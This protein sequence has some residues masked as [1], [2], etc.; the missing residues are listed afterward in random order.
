MPNIGSLLKEEISRLCRKEIRSQVEPLR[1]AS[2]AYRREIAALKRQMSVVE[3]A[4][5]HLAKRSAK[6]EAVSTKGEPNRPL[7]F[8]A[9]G[10]VSLR[11]RLGLSASELAKLLGVSDQSVYNWEHKRATPRKEQLAALATI[12][13]LGKRE[14]RARL[15]AMVDTRV[16]KP[17]KKSK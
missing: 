17:R 10:L 5:A 6:T 3:R 2:A 7:R 15:E 4:N 12:R 16:R 1:K 8:V 11:A 14:A 13:T 9:K